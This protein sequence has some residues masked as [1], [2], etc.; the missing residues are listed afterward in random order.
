M[1][2]FSKTP[3]TIESVSLLFYRDY[4]SITLAVYYLS[5]NVVRIP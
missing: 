5:Q 3:T 2:T 1:N 4:G